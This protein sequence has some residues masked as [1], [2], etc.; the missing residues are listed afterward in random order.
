MA[1]AALFGY[2]ASL[3]PNEAL[4]PTFSPPLRGVM[5]AAE[6]RRQ[7]CEWGYGHISD[8][9]QV[10]RGWKGIIAMSELERGVAW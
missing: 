6:R 7:I 4:Q 2:V 1:E 3:Q 10:E 8:C 9:S 5:A